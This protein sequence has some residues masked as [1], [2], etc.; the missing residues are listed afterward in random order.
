MKSFTLRSLG[1]LALLTLFGTVALTAQE[2]QEPA[3]VMVI[4]KIKHEDG[5]LEII[6]KRV[7][8]GENLPAVVESLGDKDANAT[9]VIVI[10]GEG[11]SPAVINGKIAEGIHVFGNMNENIEVVQETEALNKD[12][13]EFRKLMHVENGNHNFAIWTNGDGVEGKRALLGIYPGESIKGKGLAISSLVSGCGAENAGLTDGDVIVNVD[14]HSLQNTESL[15]GILSSYKP[16]D[17]VTVVY[18]RNGQQSQASVTLCAERNSWTIERDP[19]KVFIGVYTGSFGSEGRGVEVQGV[20][21]NTSAAKYGVKTGDVI[22]ALDGM[23]VNNHTELLRERNKHQA[24]DWF[25]LNILR[26][27]Q[28]MDIKAQFNPCDKEVEQPQEEVMEEVIEEVVVEE[29]PETAPVEQAAPTL[30]QAPQLQLED[31]NVYPNPTL[32][33]FTLQFKGEAVPTEIRITDANGKTVY[34]ESLQQFDGFYQKELNLG[35]KTPGLYVVTVK[36]GDLIQSDK[37]VLMPRA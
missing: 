37:V 27:G 33:R 28:A 14:G 6:K 30:Q 7:Y 36:Q 32:G 9:Q 25:T 1:V 21:E 13:A 16:G 18:L 17:Q 24:G 5:S 22:L 4:K 8:E 11:L 31:W 23:P 3:S 12:L 26:D 20:I 34:R 29:T 15:R 2:Q 19:C 35:G 10:K